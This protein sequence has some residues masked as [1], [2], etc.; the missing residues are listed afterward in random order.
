MNVKCVFVFLFLVS[1]SASAITIPWKPYS[2]P[3]IRDLNYQRQFALLPLSGEALDKD[4]NWA[5]DFWSHKLGSINRRWNAPGKPGFKLKSPDRVTAHAMTIEELSL[6]S[7][8]EKLDLLNGDYNYSVVAEV[9]K[10]ADK[11]APLWWGICNGWSPAAANHNE[12]TP[13]T[14][15][16]TDGIL[17]PFGSSDIKA[18]I[19]YYYAFRHWVPNTRQMGR[20]CT[21][22]GED[23]DEDLNAGSFHIVLA[24]TLGFEG[25]SFTADVERQDEVWN[26][27]VISYKSTIVKDNMKPAWRSAKGT[28]KRVQ[29]RS[30]VVYVSAIRANSWEPTNG[31]DAH[32]NATRIWEY[33]LDLDVNGIIIGG[34]WE[35]RVRPDFIW[36]M[37]KP[38]F[39]ADNFARLPELLND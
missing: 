29:V 30:E 38:T 37:E 8:T 1:F 33:T 28:V 10:I 35:S 9:G 3:A 4:K 34:K 39:F 7:A 17:I 19:S 11:R 14:L 31:T 36:S 21:E 27:N 12:P 2:D 24:N 6:L 32:I 22:E 20:R 13:K 5:S 16:S 15:M 23:C 26:H 25:R 18:L